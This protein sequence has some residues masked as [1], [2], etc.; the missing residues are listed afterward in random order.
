VITHDLSLKTFNLKPSAFSLQP[1]N[2][3]PSLCRIC[4]D[5]LK[6]NIPR[7]IEQFN[8]NGILVVTAKIPYNILEINT[9]IH[10]FLVD[11]QMLISRHANSSF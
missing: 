3:Q 9:H 10:R 6:K 7:Q 11:R 2:L 4:P 5:Y 8:A 1:S